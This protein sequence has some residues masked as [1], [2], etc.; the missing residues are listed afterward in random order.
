VIEIYLAVWGTAVASCLLGL[1]G[2]ALVRS[3][4]QVMPVLVVTVMGQLVLCGGMIPVTGRLVLSELSWLAPAR[5]GY[6]AGAG[7]ADLTAGAAA[8]AD[9]LWTSSLP[10][11]SLSIGILAL[12]ATVH[13][14]L[15]ILRMRR[16]AR[17]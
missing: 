7:T 6:A 15:L 14:G 17:R 13:T 2:S 8:P 5:W 11:W 12:M 3:A 16:L 1:L 10:W 4:E 9:Q